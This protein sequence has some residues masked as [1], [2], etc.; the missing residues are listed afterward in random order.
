[1]KNRKM[2]KTYWASLSRSSR[3]R[4]LISVFPLNR[5]AADML[6]EEKPNLTDPW[7]QI[8]WRHVRIPADNSHY[9]TCVNN[10]YIP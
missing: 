4:A 6:L 5:A 8:V 10:V 2:T 9:K 7:W 3:E 1:M